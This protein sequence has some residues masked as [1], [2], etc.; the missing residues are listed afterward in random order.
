MSEDAMCTP[1]ASQSWVLSQVGKRYGHWDVLGRCS[2][3]GPRDVVVLNTSKA[4]ALVPRK[5]GASNNDNS[6]SLACSPQTGNIETCTRGKNR[7]S[8][9]FLAQGCGLMQ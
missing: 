5:P 3:Q 7:R 8:D 6:P 2:E 1:D 4:H 9:T